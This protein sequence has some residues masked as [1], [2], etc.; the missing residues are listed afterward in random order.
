MTNC[1]PCKDHGLIPITIRENPYDI[2]DLCCE[3]FGVN[4]KDIKGGKR[5]AEIT[6]ARHAT[7]YLLHSD[8]NLG[9]T[10]R[11]VG[12]IFNGRDHSTVINAIMG[13]SDRMDVYQDTKK[14][15]VSLYKHVYNS[16][17]YFIL[18]GRYKMLQK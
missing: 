14:T 10:L 6:F 11:E 3:Y 8:R 16:A 9:L 13:I 4:Q 18:G 17:Y 5:N 7:M 15:M 2:L 1:L 12:N